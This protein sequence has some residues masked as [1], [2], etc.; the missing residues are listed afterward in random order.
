M[1]NNAQRFLAG[2]GMVLATLATNIG[3]AGATQPPTKALKL[4][5]VVVSAT[6]RTPIVETRDGAVIAGHAVYASYSDRRKRLAA[7][8]LEG[9][10]VQGTVDTTLYAANGACFKHQQ[11]QQFVGLSQLAKSLL[12]LP[13]R[14][15][16]VS[17]TVS[18]R[19][20]H[21]REAAT[22][23]HGVE[24]G[25][26]VFNGRDRIT[27]SQTSPYRYG[28]SKVGGQTIAVTYPTKLPGSVPG[29]P[30]KPTCKTS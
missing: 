27:S 25:T 21:W 6:D 29:A 17:Y 23:Q 14:T 30:P 3:T 13:T 9:R 15:Q 28:R 7:T 2:A 5:G 10:L 11:L 26:V 1:P 12:P 20:L 4:A 22:R 16:H 24:R 18:G 19:T 8:Y